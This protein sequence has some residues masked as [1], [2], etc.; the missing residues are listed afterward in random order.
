M[1]LFELPRKGTNL[2]HVLEFSFFLSLSAYSSLFPSVIVF[3]PMLRNRSSGFSMP[4]S[5]HSL[6]T[7]AMSISLSLALSHSV[8]ICSPSFCFSLLM[9]RSDTCILPRAFAV[10]TKL[11]HDGWTCCD[12]DVRISTWSP[13]CSLWLRGTS[14]WFTFAPMQCVPRNVCMRKAKSSTVHPAGMVFISPLGVNTNISLAKRFSLMV[15]RKSM[16]SGCGSSSISFMVLSQLFSSLSSSTLMSP[17]LYFQC[18]ANPCSATSSIL[19]L[20]ICTSIHC[21]CFDIS[22]TCSA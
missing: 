15:S 11:I 4:W 16:A 2:R 6:L 17:S 14:L 9:R 5:A 8:S 10:D 1:S 19:S 20:L 7:T 12:L 21:P 22:V 18:A 13:L 3:F